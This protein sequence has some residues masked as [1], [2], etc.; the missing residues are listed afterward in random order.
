MLVGYAIRRA[1]GIGRAIG[2]GIFPSP[3]ANRLAFI[4]KNVTLRN[5]RLL[6][7][8]KGVTLGSGVIIDA[9]SRNGVALGSNVSIGDYSII[10]ATGVIS[11]IGEG[12][13]IGSRS[14][15]G[16]FSYIGAAG[17]VS[18]GCDVIMG[19][20]VSF[21]S[22]NHRFERIDV[23]IRSQG[24]TRIGI[25]IEDDCWIG[26][27]VVFLDGARVGRGCV[28]GAG[29]VVRGNIPDYSVVVGVPAR[30]I[31]KRTLPQDLPKN[32]EPPHEI[33]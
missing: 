21:H 1:Q 10:E 9:L 7:L 20:R 27:N 14:G 3:W 22:E 13:Q 24:I 8:G 19:Q 31:R 23:S 16:A 28:I 33:A 5:R 30:V 2:H 18:I 32:C 26:A 29:S 4:G 25:V 12:C 15:L 17:G 11:R 6:R